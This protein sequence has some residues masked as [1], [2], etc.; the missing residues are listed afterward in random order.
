MLAA[1]LIALAIVVVDQLVKYWAQTVLMSLGTIPIIQDV[2]HLT[3]AQNKGAAFSILQG[4]RWF[5]VVIT[6]IIV[7][8]LLWMLYKNQLCNLWGRLSV[9]FIIGGAV[10]NFIDRLRFGYV[11]DMMD[12]RLINFAIFNVADMFLT[13]GGIMLIIYIL[14]MDGKKEDKNREA[15]QD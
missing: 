8:V 10:G 4:Q 14:F 11:I 13:V 6:V 12:F 7:G 5:F 3:Y 2:F 1:I 15:A 9:I